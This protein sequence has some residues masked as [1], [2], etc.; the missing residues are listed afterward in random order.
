MTTYLFAHLYIAVQISV[1]VNCDQLLLFF[2]VI[3]YIICNC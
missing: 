2:Y 3:N 1:I